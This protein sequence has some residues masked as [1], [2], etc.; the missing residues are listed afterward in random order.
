MRRAAPR[1]DPDFGGYDRRSTLGLPEI[2]GD[3]AIEVAKEAQRQNRG[4]RS[5]KPS[6]WGGRPTRRRFPS[7][8]SSG[9]FKLPKDP[10]GD[11]K[12]GGGF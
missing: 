12:T 6:P 3:I 9:G 5:R 11:F 8:R 10:G 4:H 7:R 1:T 2:L